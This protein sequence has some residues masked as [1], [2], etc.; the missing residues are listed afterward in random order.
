MTGNDRKV[1]EYDQS[2][3]TISKMN[4]YGP[5]PLLS[6]HYRQNFRRGQL[7]PPYKFSDP[8]YIMPNKLYSFQEIQIFEMHITLVPLLH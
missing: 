6:I 2:A 3:L 7:Y 8:E 5:F 4:A 1:V